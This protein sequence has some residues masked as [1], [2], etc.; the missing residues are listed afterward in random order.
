MFDFPYFLNTFFTLL[1]GVPITLLIAVV[2]FFCGSVIGFLIALIR[3]YSIPFISQVAIFYVSLFRGTPLLVQIF[4]FYYG[5]PIFI[6]SMGLDSS[7]TNI[8]AMYYAFVA[9]SFYASAYLS[10]IFRAAML[11][12]DKGQR[13]AGYSLGMNNMQTLRRI[14]IP[15]SLMNT[16]PNLLN[17]FIMLIK[18]TSIASVIT[19]REL[20]GL[21]E[22]EIG[23]S[24]QFLEVYLMAALMYWVLCIVLEWIFGKIEN[25]FKK[26]RREYA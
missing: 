18:D 15:Q 25:R 5:I 2:A 12:V 20:M 21:A 8:D 7:F 9:F 4:V 24:S 26:F 1:P 6:K 10:E 23:R 22:I 19:V 16:L 14:V 13:E 17:F 11:S 3:L